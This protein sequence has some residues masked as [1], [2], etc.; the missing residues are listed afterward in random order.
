[1][2]GKVALTFDDGPYIY[3]NDLLNLLKSN[4][5]TATFFVVG[6][7]GGKGQIQDPKTGYPAI[8][9]RMYAEDTRSRA[10]PGAIR[11]LVRLRPS[12]AM[13]K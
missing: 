2:T 12:S 8:I 10:I 13:T 9:Q 5:V 11:T 3:T 4:N 6:A 7:N 1:M